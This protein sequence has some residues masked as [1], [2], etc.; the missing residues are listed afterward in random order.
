MGAGRPPRSNRASRCPAPIARP[1]PRPAHRRVNASA[2]MGRAMGLRQSPHR[3]GRI[4]WHFAGCDAE[5]IS[6]AA[7]QG[8][9]AEA[10]QG[11]TDPHWYATE[12]EGQVW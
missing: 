5:G 1:S 4:C 11:A 10:L 2:S 9:H 12:Q 6:D 3:T 8:T 7:L